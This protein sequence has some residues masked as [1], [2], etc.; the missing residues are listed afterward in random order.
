MS[1][2]IIPLTID[3]YH[4]LNSDKSGISRIDLYLRLDD[5]NIPPS[6]MTRILNIEPYEV[7][8][9]GRTCTLRSGREYTPESNSWTVFRSYPVNN[10]YAENALKSFIDEIVLPNYDKLKEITSSASAKL[11]FV[12]YYYDSHNMGIFLDHKINSL[13]SGLNIDIDFDLYCLYA[14]KN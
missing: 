1:D 3:Q 14:D 12:Y 9:K 2:E 4:E 8:E 6:E 10:T 13:L 11:E 7:Y 5:K